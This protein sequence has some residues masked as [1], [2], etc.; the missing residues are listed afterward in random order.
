[1]WPP[2]V[3]SRNFC[4]AMGEVTGSLTLQVHSHFP[5]SERFCPG[6]HFKMLVTL[7]GKLPA[8]LSPLRYLHCHL[9]SNKF[10]IKLLI[11]TQSVP[12]LSK[13]QLHVLFC[14][15]Q[16][17]WSPL[18]VLSTTHTPL[19]NH[20]QISLAWPSNMSEIWPLLLLFPDPSYCDLSPGLLHV[21][22]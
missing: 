10:K 19:P 6:R 17:T 5:S 3:S 8:L 9:K 22:S 15:E 1:M 16:K 14:S 12:D 7:L 13:W 18:W 4:G 11:S 2:L 21:S 20:Q